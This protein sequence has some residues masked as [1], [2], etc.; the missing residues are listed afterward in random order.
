MYSHDLELQ[1]IWHPALFTCN[2]KLTQ[3]H[4][5][6]EVPTESQF[7]AST[8]LV[9]RSNLLT[10]KGSGVTSLIPWACG[11]VEAL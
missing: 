11:G 7:T 2:M 1:A 5:G 9:P 4:A 3:C 8:S 6:I 10:R